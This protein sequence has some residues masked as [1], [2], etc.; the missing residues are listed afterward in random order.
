VN[1]IP[2]AYTT[3]RVSTQQGQ[4]DVSVFA[5]QFDSN[6][7]YHF[8]T[9]TQAG[10]GLGPF[11]SMVGSVRRLSAG[12]ASAIRPRVLDVVT[13][14]PGDTLQ[15]L[16]GRMAYRDFQLERFLTLNSL[17]ANSQLRPGDKVKLVVYGNRA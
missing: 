6:R 7:A 16:A 2:A 11:S 14:R 8:A 3:A 5:Y 4:V 10:A 1:G 15:S 17:Q 9:I 13:V 12:E